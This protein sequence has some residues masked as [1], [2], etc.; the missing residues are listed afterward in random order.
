M[1]LQLRILT[2]VLLVTATWGLVFLN[3]D[4]LLSEEV[5]AVQA[6][7]RN[8]KPLVVKVILERNYMDGEMSEEVVYEK[9]LAMEDFWAKYKDW[10]LLDMREGIVKFSKGVDDISP[11]LKTNGYFGVT[12]DGVL[13]I[14]NGKPSEEQIIQSFFQIDMR[15]LESVDRKR[16]ERGI[17][18]SSKNQYVEV[19]NAFKNYS[20]E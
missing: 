4:S 16:L 2:F 18:I 7:A 19:L 8:M 3:S 14:F 10:Q 5:Q 13:S 17:R 1:T 11:L 12:N 9:I 15:K 6:T 20:K